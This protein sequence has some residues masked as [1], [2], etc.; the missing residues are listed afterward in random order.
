MCGGEGVNDLKRIRRRINGGRQKEKRYLAAGIFNRLILLLMALCVCSLMLMI[1]VKL[2]FTYALNAWD[3]L[4]SL[5]WSEFLPFET[6]FQNEQINSVAAMQEYE[7]V[8]THRYHNGSNEALAPFTGMVQHIEPQNETQC[9]SLLLDDGTLVNIANLQDVAVKEQ[10][11]IQAG[12]TLGTYTEY[13]EI[14]CF[15]DGEEIAFEDMGA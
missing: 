8:G 12:S 11:R 6:W 5:Q 15:K 13:V 7:Q 2:K 3:Y 4:Q 1:G 14:R 9:V 10:E